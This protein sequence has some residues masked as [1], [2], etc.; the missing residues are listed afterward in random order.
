MNLKTLSNDGKNI[1]V[2]VLVASGRTEDFGPYS[3]DLLK[4]LFDED[5]IDGKAFI[6]SP[7]LDNWKI[8]ADFNDFHDFFGEKPPEIDALERR[9]NSRVE[10]STACRIYTDKNIYVATANDLS[11]LALKVLIKDHA[12][13]LSDIVVVEF[14]DPI[15]TGEKFSAQ[16]MRLFDSNGNETALTLKFNGLSAVQ[17]E[18]ISSVVHYNI[19][20]S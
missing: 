20:N 17:I 9:L 19:L 11:M 10:I 7:S 13:E 16:V 5:R 6:Y 2:K 14:D 15:L 12:L 3:L 8:L 18:K 4:K 1:F